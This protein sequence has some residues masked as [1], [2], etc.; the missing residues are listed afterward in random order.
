MFLPKL[1]NDCNDWNVWL[2]V[3]WRKCSIA[4]NKNAMLVIEETV[5]T[6]SNKQMSVFF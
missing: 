2:Y 1:V 5:A 6:W 3:P 4:H